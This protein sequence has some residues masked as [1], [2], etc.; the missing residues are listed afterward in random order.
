MPRLLPAVSSH[1]PETVSTST[2]APLP[3]VC[4]DTA[5][6]TCTAQMPCTMQHLPQ[7]FPDLSLRFCAYTNTNNNKIIIV[8]LQ[9]QASAVTA[10][11]LAASFRSLPWFSPKS[12][13][14]AL[15]RLHLYF[16]S[17][18]LAAEPWSHLFNVKLPV[19]L[20]LAFPS[21]KVTTKIQLTVASEQ[22]EGNT[23]AP[24]LPSG[25]REGAKGEIQEQRPIYSVNLILPYRPQYLYHIGQSCNKYQYK[26]IL[27]SLQ[28]G[29]LISLSSNLHVPCNF[30]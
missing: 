25:E 16:T 3:S 24:A 28:R 23:Q 29:H 21:L 2:G 13:A 7:W 18:C 14:C 17:L 8:K 26:T 6:T 27:I 10:G 9:E 19:T 1:R 30:S 22:S 11:D 15:G 20:I 5:V 12:L 4:W